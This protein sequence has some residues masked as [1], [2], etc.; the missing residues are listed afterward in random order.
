MIL[1]NKIKSLSSQFASGYFGVVLGMIGTGM[2]WRYA[3]KEHNYPSSIGE[4]FIGAG[5][6]IWLVLVLFFLTK[7]FCNK[8][9]I[10]NEFKHPVASGFSSLL[11][12]TTVLVAIG[13]TPYF[14]VI[15]LVLFSL[16]A[17]VQLLYAC[18]LVGYQWKG[19]H[20]KAAT[21]PAL[22]LPTVANN[23][24]CTMACGA[25]GFN[26]L[27]I[28]F[29]GA[30]VFSWL[31]LEP[32]ILKR[33]RSEGLM[34]EK[35]RLSFGIQLAPALVACSAYLA[36]NNNHVDFFAKM[37]L[38]YGLLQLFFMLRLAPWL[39]K[40]PFSL[41]FW[42]F[43][44]GISALAKSSLNMSMASDSIFIKLLSISLFVFSNLIILLLILG[45]LF[46]ILKGVKQLFS[47]Q[48]TNVEIE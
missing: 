10:I 12:A 45:S 17:T 27:G 15:S 44:F 33:I 32:A 16:G 31:S 37:L 30:G 23:F 26:D 29:F 42:S 6:V 41:P 13:L 3:A 38:G 46:W 24:I 2:A 8:Q 9:S 36:I 35:S 20:P 11:P 28:L 4:I 19:E 40:Q 39:F 43:S 25:F 34:D 21:T 5:C 47:V 14:S 48:E 18:W 7:L 1:I 22:Y